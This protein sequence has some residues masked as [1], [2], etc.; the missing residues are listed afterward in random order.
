MVN[1]SEEEVNSAA[2]EG[3]QEAAVEIIPEDVHV[4]GR[5]LYATRRR[6]RLR[7]N[8]A[9]KEKVDLQTEKPRKRIVRLE[10]SSD[11]EEERGVKRRKSLDAE[12]NSFFKR[13]VETRKALDLHSF[14]G[15][16]PSQIVERVTK[17]AAQQQER[18]TV[19]F[20]NRL[21]LSEPLGF[22]EFRTTSLVAVKV[23]YSRS[24][25]S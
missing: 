24:S 1:T 18:I 20:S 14:P 13:H 22:Q 7:Q 4:D 23:R 3:Q 5:K 21:P 2:D 12:E 10:D 11:D 6:V 15:S 17:Q 16:E 8:W 19:R 9:E 25:S